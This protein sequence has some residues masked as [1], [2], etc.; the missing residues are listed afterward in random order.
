[1]EYPGHGQDRL[2][3]EEETMRTAEAIKDVHG[4]DEKPVDQ[5]HDVLAA[6]QRRDEVAT[7]L[8]E[9]QQRVRELNEIIAPPKRRIETA[10]AMTVM[11]FTAGTGF[12]PREHI[13]VTE[14]WEQPEVDPLAARRAR[15]ALPAVEIQALDLQAALDAAERALADTRRAAWARRTP[16]SDAK[17]R[18]AVRDFARDLERL[19]GKAQLLLAAIDQEN[20]RL[21]PDEHGRLRYHAPE[22]TFPPLTSSD[23]RVP[24]L[25]AFWRERAVAAGWL[26]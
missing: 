8:V 3:P 18:S 2:K 15:L 25:A 19:A 9:A 21:G 22:I 26:E 11:A 5:D 16:V 20:A 4:T 13:D 24:S 7:Q 14:R 23:P 17:I 6:Q 10:K 1:M 12:G